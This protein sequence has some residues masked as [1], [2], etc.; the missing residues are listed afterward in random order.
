[1][2]FSMEKNLTSNEMINIFGSMV[3]KVA[4]VLNYDYCGGGKL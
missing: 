1:M 2:N 4:C 3:K